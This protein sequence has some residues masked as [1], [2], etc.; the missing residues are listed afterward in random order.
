M[1]QLLDPGPGPGHDEED[2]P[3]SGTYVEPAC[4]PALSPAR[5]R[6]SDGE[7]RTKRERS[8]EREGCAPAPHTGTGAA[9][10]LL[11]T[12]REAVS[13]RFASVGGTTKVPFFPIASARVVSSSPSLGRVAKPVFLI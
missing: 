4:C 6:V 13:A 9:I 5:Q 3:R 11:Y 2:A 7:D 10:F 8:G 12:G 1:A